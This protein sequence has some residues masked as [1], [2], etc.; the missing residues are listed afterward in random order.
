M[1]TLASCSS[2][3][4]IT[5]AKIKPVGLVE[6]HAFYQIRPLNTKLNMHWKN[7]EECVEEK[8]EREEVD[9]QTKRQELEATFCSANACK[10][11]LLL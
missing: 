4:N 11:F 10:L 7:N 2:C 5:Q 1:P 8:P 3:Y 9:Q 6:F